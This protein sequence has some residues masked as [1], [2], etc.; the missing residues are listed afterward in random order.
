MMMMM[1]MFCSQVDK[2][3][4]LSSNYNFP[5]SSITVRE[6]HTHHLLIFHDC[7]HHW[8]K[9]S[10]WYFASTW[11]KT[12]HPKNNFSD[13][14]LLLCASYYYYY[15]YH[16]YHYYY[17]SDVCIPL[18]ASC[19]QHPRNWLWAKHAASGVRQ[20]IITSLVI[21]IVILIII[22]III[23]ITIITIR[24]ERRSGRLYGS[25]GTQTLT[26]SQLR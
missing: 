19:S 17:I 11:W 7:L 16:Y 5:V 1:M 24:M 22:V 25:S 3:G 6:N 15:Y 23:I 9:W 2:K 10:T 13:I 14:C 8:W 18:C 12:F 21:I 20:I 4:R 26:A